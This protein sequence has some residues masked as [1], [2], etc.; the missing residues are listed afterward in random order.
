MH[1]VK[2]VANHKISFWFLFK[3]IFLLTILFSNY[4][5]LSNS[6]KLTLLRH[7]IQSAFALKNMPIT[8][9]Y[10]NLNGAGS[11]LLNTENLENTPLATFVWCHFKI[12]EKIMYVKFFLFLS[13]GRGIAA[14]LGLFV[15][16]IQF[17]TSSI[18]QL[19]NLLILPLDFQI[20]TFLS[21]W[22][23]VAIWDI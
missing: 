18:Q 17:F 3:Y 12:L 10:K 2:N 8:V 22:H 1:C 5:T 13:E 20:T 4:F 23:F 7:L 19:F 21:S 11:A 6:R 9:K 14:A 15:T 16:F